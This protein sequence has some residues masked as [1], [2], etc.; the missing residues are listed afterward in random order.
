MKVSK[1][2]AI[3]ILVML[4]ITLLSFTLSIE[5]VT[6]TIKSKGRAETVL[7]SDGSWTTECSNQTDD[8]CSITVH[9]THD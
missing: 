8:T 9:M 7:R 1:I 4:V 2:K 6:A 3:T 5:S